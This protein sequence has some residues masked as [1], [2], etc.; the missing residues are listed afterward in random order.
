MIS[1]NLDIRSSEH[2]YDFWDVVLRGDSIYPNSGNRVFD[3]FQMP[4][5][6][7]ALELR[8]RET[9]RHTIRVARLT[10]RLARFM[11]V[12]DNELEIIN[13]GALLHDIGKLGVPD[14][15]LLKPGPLDEAEWEIMR[16][17]PGLA[18]EILSLIPELQSAI[19]IPYCH[20]ER[21][22]G[23]G[24]PRG[25]KAEEIPF[26]ARIFSVI[27][28]WDALTSDRPYRRAWSPERALKY[29]QLGS[30]QQFDPDAVNAFL[31]LIATNQLFQTENVDFIPSD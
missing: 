2:P 9:I 12:S 21:W 22:D 30:G 6:S 20:H 10:V 17:H 1:G 16:Q 19:D 15:I 31:Y 28:V 5:W 3:E 23:T 13:R 8:D 26:A 11:G 18:F 27:D 14:R 29:I 25:L 4:D 24:Y 7:K